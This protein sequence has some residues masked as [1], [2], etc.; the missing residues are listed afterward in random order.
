M[1]FYIKHSDPDR[2]CLIY[3]E[4]GVF[5]PVSM[6]RYLQCV[7]VARR[8]G[9]YTPL[10]KGNPRTQIIECLLEKLFLWW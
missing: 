8:V 5:P 9:G 6:S 2:N 7:G 3:P 10:A 1:S 4:R